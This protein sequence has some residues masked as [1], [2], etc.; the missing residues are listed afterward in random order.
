MIKYKTSGKDI[1]TQLKDKGFTTT[2]LR[3][4]KLLSESTIQKLRKDDITITLAT[5]ETLCNLL[6]C[7]INDL[8]IYEN[9]KKMGRYN[10]MYL[11]IIYVIIFANN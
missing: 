8:I 10:Y 9:D 7:D 2:K 6:D 11:P 4:E 3:N 1:L 5:I